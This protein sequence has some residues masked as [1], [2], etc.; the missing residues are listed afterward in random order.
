MENTNNK[1]SLSVGMRIKKARIL[2]QKK[3]LKKTGKNHGYK[4]NYFAMA[5]F[6]PTVNE[7]FDELNLV[8]SFKILDQYAELTIYS[9]EDLND[10]MVYILNLPSN[11]EDIVIGGR[12]ENNNPLQVMGAIQTYTLKY[13]YI[14]ALNLVEGEMIDN[15]EPEDKD[16][17][18]TS[19][20]TSTDDGSDVFYMINHSQSLDDLNKVLSDFKTDMT[21][22]AKTLLHHIATERYHGDFKQDLGKYVVASVM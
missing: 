5:D 2:I 12:R 1:E 8:S 18:K 19:N 14:G 16:E 20:K 9:A 11:K 13:L 21:K 4:F 7:I 15:I 3:N 6:I 10:K 17:N 22:E